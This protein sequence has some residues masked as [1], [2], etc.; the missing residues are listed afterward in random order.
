[1][2]FALVHVVPGPF[3]DPFPPWEGFH[4][5]FVRAYGGVD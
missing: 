4:L 3:H 5:D 2:A 1:M